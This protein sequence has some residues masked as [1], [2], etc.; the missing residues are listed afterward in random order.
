MMAVVSVSLFFLFFSF[1]LWSLELVVTSAEKM[2]LLCK[3]ILKVRSVIIIQTF[4]GKRTSFW[5]Q[6][7]FRERLPYSIHHWTCRSSFSF[8]LA[9]LLSLFILLPSFDAGSL[10][11]VKTP[12]FQWHWE[13]L[14]AYHRFWLNPDFFLARG[15]DF[16]LSLGV[17][18]PIITPLMAISCAGSFGND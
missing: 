1:F 12:S 5:F 18:T 16:L 15:F 7:L 3:T 9:D 6:S 14:E 17:T 11:G 13:R 4:L 10:L 2:F 8:Q